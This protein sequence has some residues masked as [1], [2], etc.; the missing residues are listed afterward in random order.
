MTPQGRPLWANRWD[1]F[2]EVEA[3]VTAVSV[4]VPYYR[5]QSELDRTLAAL[6]RQTYP[7]DLV[8]IVVVDDGSPEAPSVPGGVRVLRQE[9]KGFRL[10]AARNLGAREA[11]HDLLCFLDADTSP[12][13]GYLERLVRLPA[14]APEIVTVGRRRHADLSGVPTDAP[15]EDVGPKH[16]LDEPVWLRDAYAASR[17]LL[18]SDD[19]SYR[20]LIGAVLACGRAVFDEI[21]G[22]D[23]R[24]QDYGGE[25]WDWAYRM[26]L[27]GAGFAH[28]PD[29][30]AWHDGPDWAGRDGTDEQ[31]RLQGNEETLTLAERIPVAGSGPRALIGPEDDICI[32][33]HAA[34]S[35]A[36][37]FICVD[38]LLDALPRARV[39]VPHEFLGLFEHDPRVRACAPTDREERLPARVRI[40]VGEAVRVDEPGALRRAVAEVGVGDLGGIE[41]LSPA[42][43][44]FRVRANR[45]MVRERRWGAPQFSSRTEQ[46]DWLRD[47]ET[48]PRLAAYLGGWD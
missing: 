29:A 19:R 1:H 32:T 45:S 6:Q 39:I 22:F 9:D 46:S 8:E 14:I 24:F 43:A 33:L 34:R 18:D 35:R 25:D 47:F 17:N 21:G 30:V 10:A 15:I 2:D 23:E 48:E 12:E 42:G 44:S 13:P 16:A 5:Q 28:V 36:A 7:Q 4:I 40:D 27:A 41:F 31:R 3:P 26:W 37:A 11:R 38:S 20:Y